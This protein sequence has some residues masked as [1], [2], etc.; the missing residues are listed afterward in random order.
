MLA[1][2][3]IPLAQRPRDRYLMLCFVAFAC[4]SFM[5]DRLAALDVDVCGEQSL[6]GSLCW[7]GRNLDPLF[8][9]NPQWLRVLSGISAWVFGPLYVL[10]AWAVWRGLDSVVP[11]ARAWAVAMLYSM[12]VHLYMEY[13][14]DY[15]P[16][17][18]WLLLGVY[19]PY[20]VLPVLVLVR[21]RDDRPFTRMVELE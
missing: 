9:A 17:R 1:P 12:V 8:L 14:G 16:P 4:T 11:I 18:P 20:A 19:L 6:G 5:V 21:L 3:P 15:P 13:F 2:Q 10:F 7:Y